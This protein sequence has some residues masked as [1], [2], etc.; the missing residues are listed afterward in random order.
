MCI[1]RCCSFWPTKKCWIDECVWAG[2]MDQ[3]DVPQG[4]L[5]AGLRK[6]R[7]GMFQAVNAK[8]KVDLRNSIMIGDSASDLIAAFGAGV[9]HCYLL[10]SAKIADAKEELQNFQSLNAL[11]TYTT[12]QNFSDLKI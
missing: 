5:Y 9:G 10:S 11:F 6:P 4:R 7:V 3:E 2:F 8:L 1:K 12:V